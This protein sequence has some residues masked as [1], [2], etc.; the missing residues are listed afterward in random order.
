MRSGVHG[1]EKVMRGVHV[2]DALELTHELLDLLGDLGADRTSG[3]SERER[4]GDLAPVD[5]DLIDEP[6][7]DEVESQLRIDDVRQGVGDGFFADHGP[8]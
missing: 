5:L 7:L 4:H 6:Q 8:V 1:G 3:R 2:L